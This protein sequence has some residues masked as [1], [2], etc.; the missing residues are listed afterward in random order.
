[1]FARKIRGNNRRDINLCFKLI[2]GSTNIVNK[3]AEMNIKP[4][5]SKDIRIGIM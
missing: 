4:V 1:M 3:K 2:S 5:H